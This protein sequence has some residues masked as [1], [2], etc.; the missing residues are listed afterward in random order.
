MHE[1][2]LFIDAISTDQD[3]YTISVDT[4]TD[5]IACND[6]FYTITEALNGAA[7]FIKE[8]K[9]SYDVIF[10]EE[11]FFISQHALEQ[12]KHYDLTAHKMLKEIKQAKIIGIDM[13]KE[14][15]L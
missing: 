7:D 5:V 8:I 2:K 10:H 15:D 13:E 4:G 6:T 9:E 3:G 11:D 14:N 1:G 12:N